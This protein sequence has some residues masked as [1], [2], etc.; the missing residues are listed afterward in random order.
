MGFRLE[1]VGDIL[2]WL[3]LLYHFMNLNLNIKKGEPNSDSVR[4]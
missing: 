4:H 2:N 1:Y 3:I